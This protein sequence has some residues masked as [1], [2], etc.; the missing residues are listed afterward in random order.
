MRVTRVVPNLT[1]S[2]T[3]AANRF[4]ADTLGFTIADDFGWVGF[5]T[6]PESGPVELHT[7]T[8]DE[9]APVESVVSIAVDDVDEAYRR[10][11]EAGADIVHEL[12]EEQW[13]VRRFFFRDPDGNVIN[14][15]AHR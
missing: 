7:V 13:G 10:V 15:V 4:Y 5:L 2:D 12:Q 3:A 6:A 8:H 11:R 14:V 9:T 1:V